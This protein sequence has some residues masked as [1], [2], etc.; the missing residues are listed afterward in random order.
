MWKPLPSI[1]VL[2]TLKGS[3][4][5]KAQRGQYL[6]TV[7]LG[8]YKWYQS[9]TLGDVPMRRLSPKRGGNEAVCQ[10]GR[11]PRR[12]WI[13]GSHIN[14]RK[15]MS[16]SEDV[17]GPADVRSHSLSPTDVR[18]HTP[19]PFGA[20]HPHWHSFPSPV[21]VGPQRFPHPYKEC[22]ILLPN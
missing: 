11:W 8:H 1:H 20:Q 18:S 21:D 5:G 14:W 22:F 3:P 12:G 7:S 10:Q 15:G 6:L 2:K 9:Q 19:P 4:K 16:A 13:G 17:R